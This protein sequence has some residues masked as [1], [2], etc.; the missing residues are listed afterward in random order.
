MPHCPACGAANPDEAR[1]CREC[2]TRLESYARA[3][4][5]WEPE[6]EIPQPRTTPVPGTGS[7]IK[8]I[9]IS[10]ASLILGLL[11]TGPLALIV[12]WLALRRHAPNPGQAKAGLALGI[13]GTVVLA[14]IVTARLAAGDPLRRP[15]TPERVPEFVAGISERAGKIEARADRLLEKLG[16]GAEGELAEVFSA[17]RTID[18][19]VAELDSTPPEM[20]D[21]IRDYIFEELDRARSA[22]GNR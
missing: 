20:L 5:T 22:L 21:T 7:A 4:E 3:R 16:P 11:G 10:T 15:L 12:G 6:E 2:R 8:S 1:F 18:D 17:L 13:A 19:L 14:A 9:G